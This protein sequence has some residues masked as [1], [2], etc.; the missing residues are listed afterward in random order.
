MRW[1]DPNVQRSW[2][3]AVDVPDHLRKT[4]Y[5]THTPDGMPLEPWVKPNIRLFSSYITAN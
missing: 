4:F 2:S 3:W 5:E 1:E